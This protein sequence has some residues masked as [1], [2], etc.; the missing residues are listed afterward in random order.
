MQRHSYFIRAF[1]LIVL[2]FLLL[3]APSFAA[4][5]FPGAEGFGANTIGGR[6]GH[7]YEVTSL[8]DSGT[9]S[10]RECVNA[11]GP[12]ICVFRVGGLITLSTPLVISNPYITIAGQTAPGGGIT[13][14]KASGGDVFSTRTHDV[15]MRY[16][17]VRP[18]PGGENHADQIGVNNVALNNILIDHCTFSWGVDSN[19]ETWYRVTNATIQWSMIS[20]ALDC[21]TH[22]K[23][24][25]SK[26]LMIGG[27][28]G[29]EAGTTMGAENV[30]VLHNLIAHSGERTPLMQLCGPAQVINNVTYNPYWAFAEQQ[31]DCVLPSNNTINW[32]GNYNKK[33]P[34]STSNS[35]LIV[36]PADSGIYAGYSKAYVKGNIGPS[37]PNDTYPESNWVDS[38]YRTFVVTSP[39]AAPSVTTTDATTAFNDV[40]ADVGNNR[41]LTCDGAWFNRRDSIDARVV[42]DVKNGTGHIIDD[43]AEVGGWIT[44]APGTQCQDSDHDG[45]PDA[46]ELLHG[47]NPADQSDAA[48]VNSSGY[49]N[50]DEYLAGSAVINTLAAPTGLH[51]VNVN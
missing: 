32:I 42:N 38:R 8:S 41:G 7:V 46:W 28:A 4:S 3:Q 21:S 25:H 39:V 14:R 5:G 18:G 49:T 2:P 48:K 19:I 1:V 15:I 35:G 11:S 17:T 30:S 24:C 23:G 12:R 31:D 37:R 34:D 26:G 13:L 10:L 27:F 33:G 51:V 29:N 9:G 22:S 16:L 6:G 47:L 36:I 20:E 50:L 45:I 40:L 43:P 44:P